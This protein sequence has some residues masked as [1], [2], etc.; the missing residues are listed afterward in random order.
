MMMSLILTDRLWDDS[1]IRFCSKLF[2]VTKFEILGYLDCLRKMNASA[3][4]WWPNPWS[5][6][7]FSLVAS[8]LSVSLC[9]MSSQRHWPQNQ[10]NQEERIVKKRAR[11]GA[12]G[13]LFKGSRFKSSTEGTRTVLSSSQRAGLSCSHS[14]ASPENLEH[15]WG[16]MGTKHGAHGCH[17]AP[18]SGSWCHHTQGTCDFHCSTVRNCGAARNA[19][20]RDLQFK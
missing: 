18:R 2:W 1:G 13:R 15:H 4:T 7:R 11:T 14:P 9:L 19:V 17:E 20:L 10:N 3:W 8:R 5:S 6:C 12:D 16:A